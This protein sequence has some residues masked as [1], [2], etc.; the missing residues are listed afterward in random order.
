MKKAAFRVLASL[1]LVTA[2]SAFVAIEGA[3]AQALPGTAGAATPKLRST[4]PAQRE[5][6]AARVSAARQSQQNEIMPGLVISPPAQAVAPVPGGTPDYF[7]IYPNYANSPVPTV[8]PITKLITGGMRKFVDTLPGVGSANANNLGQYIPVAVPDTATYPGSDYYQ[9]GLVNYT[10]QMHSDLPPTQLRGYVDLAPA[11]DGH[12]H[13][14]G[15]LIIARRDRAVRVKFTNML[16]VSGTPGSDLFLPVDTTI[17]GAGMGPD[18]MNAYTQNRAVLHLHGGATPWISDGTPHQ[19]VTPAGDTATY[20]KGVS[21]QNVPDMPDP[22][23]GSATYYWTNE[24][25][26]RLMFYHDHSYGTT[27]LN[28]YAGEAS[29]YLVTDPAEDYLI[30][31]GVLPNLGGVYRYGIP[32]IIQ[33]RTFV[34]ANKIA[35]QDPTWNW[36]TTPPVPHTGDLWFPHVYMPN[37]NP[38][39]PEGVNAMGRWDYGPWFWP[40][41]TT[42][43]HMPTASVPGGILDTPATPNPSLVPEAFMDTPVVNGTAYPVLKVGRKAYRFRILNACND[44]YLNLQLYLADPAH[45]TEVKMVPAVQHAGYPADWPTDGRVGGVP[46]P[47]TSGPAMIQIGDEGGMLPAPVVLPNKPI[48]Y[49]YNRRDITVLNVSTH[50]LLLGPAERADVIIDFSKVP[51]G[52]KVILYNDAPAPVPGF[53]PRNDYYTGDPDQTSTGGAP[54]T[55]AGYGPNTRTIMQFKVSGRK[56]PAFNLAALQAALPG[57]YAASQ[58]GPVVPESAYGT[59]YGSAFPDTY[60]A[61]QDTSL[62]YTPIGA[63]APVITPM[64]PKAI[65]EL[66]ELNYGRMNATLGVELPFTNFNTQTTIPYGYIDP[67][68]EAISS[69]ETQ[70]WKIT[71][72]GVDTH[73]IHFHLF[74]VQ[75]INRVGWDGM[76]KPPDANE[77]GWKETVRMNPLEDCIVAL[78]PATP[79]LPFVVPDSN[80]LLDPTMPQGSTG[81]FANI[82]PAN[83][84]P[85]VVYNDPTSYHW[86]YV[87]HCH[88]LGHEE[89][90]MMRA[91]VFTPSPDYVT[92]VA[93]P[94]DLS[95]AVTGA[96]TVT[97][98]WTDNSGNE[99]GFRIERATGAG[100]F[101]EVGTVA[102]NVTTYNDATAL[103]GATYTYRVFAYNVAGDSLP[104]DYVSIAA[105]APT[106]P[107]TLHAVASARGV[108]PSTVTLSWNDNSNNETGFTIQRSSGPS[109]KKAVSIFA[110]GPNTTSFVDT[111]VVSKKVYYY[112]VAAAN[113]VGSSAWSNAAHATTH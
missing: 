33:D 36:G 42:L 103:P 78:K 69:G 41:V 51:S 12:T 13:Y 75:L 9:I 87:W 90:D 49:V 77:I 47:H 96:Q 16:P 32:L 40:P 105:V 100:A 23:D 70:I 110:A 93:L 39:D 82:N 66:F 84:A 72:N 54:T 71:H 43:A 20:R 50:T 61:I 76:V 83:N 92:P 21:A 80:R 14:L 1:L 81:Q 64:Q 63:G 112:R 24:Q 89:N 88:L 99:T 46:N 17:M 11:A 35:A 8:N 26:S 73:A 65:Q 111:T 30:D 2:V 109:F 104:S 48:D 79:R 98:N 59:P 25:S 97:L 19:W 67:P 55:L 44:R 56:S 62:T 85:I 45:P 60:S 22:G 6:A 108:N 10:Q 15:P 38:H 31:S 94:L 4:T 52:A 101:T 86:E 29:G 113:G 7:G 27:R 3:Q 37:Q 74:N 58:G 102:A 53:D 5:A 18:G 34:D 91:I 28:V 106:A 68:T 95:A 107:T 57:A